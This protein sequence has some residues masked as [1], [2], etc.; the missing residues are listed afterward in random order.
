MEPITV[1]FLHTDNREVKERIVG[2]GGTGLVIQRGQF[3]VKIPRLRREVKMVDG[4]RTIGRLTPNPGDY[5]DRQI[6]IQYIQDEK[7]I[8]RRLQQYPGIIQCYDL[9]STDH[10]IQMK[11]LEKGDL[12]HYLARTKPD[13]R[14]QLSW[15]VDLAYTLVYVHEHRI[16]V[17]DLRTDNI[18]LDDDFSVKMIDFSE[19][20]MMPPDWDMQGTVDLGYSISTDIGAFG[21][22][23]YEIVTGQHCKFNLLQHWKEP[24][25]PFQ[26]PSRE[27]LPETE[28]VW[29]SHII[30]RCWTEG[31]FVSAQE[32]VAAL[33]Q[34]LPKPGED[35][36]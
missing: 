36:Q 27:S 17:C 11:L 14:T 29:L 15:L 6:G 19:S 16:V 24:G 26:W 22:I 34:E 35:P 20:I 8:Y 32:I 30:E 12:R 18:L 13:R 1:A 33:E 23:I 4:E 5:D 2:I 25:D 21:T 28:S 7:A 3:A 9:D 31:S 10:S